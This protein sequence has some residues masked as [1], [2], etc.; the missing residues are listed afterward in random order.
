[1]SRFERCLSLCF[2]VALVAA[3]PACKRGGETTVSPTIGRRAATHEA[4]VRILE[5]RDEY[6]FAADGSYVRTTTQKYEILTQDGVEGWG[7]TGVAYSPWYMERPELTATVTSPG[8]DKAELDPSTIAESPAYPSAPDIYSDARI[9]RAPLPNVTVGAIVEEKTVVRTTKA[10]FAGGSAHSMLVQSGVAR[11][12]VELVIDLPD[13]L[14]FEF[15]IRDADIAMKERREGGRRVIAFSGGPYAALENPEPYLPKDVAT[16][17]EVQFSTGTSWQAIAKEYGEI[18]DDKL[19][20]FSVPADAMK[21]LDRRAS[22]RDKAEHM[23]AWLRKG[24]RYTG[25]EFG[26]SAIVPAV[27]KDTLGRGYGDCKDQAILLLGL[28]KEAGVDARVALLRV[29]AGEDVRPQLPALNVFDH[30]IVYVPGKD[31]LWIDPTSDYARAGE[32]P[33]PD[34]DRLALVIDGKTKQL[35]ATPRSTADDNTYREE[36]EVFLADI[37][38]SRIVETTSSTGSIERGLRGQFRST[39]KELREG[40]GEYIEGA[41]NSK[42]LGKVDAADAADLSKP[43]VFSLEAKKAK[44]GYTTLFSAEAI[45]GYGSLFEWIPTGI[46]GEQQRR[47]DLVLPLSHRTQVAYTVH[48][49]SGFVHRDPP[50]FRDLDLGAMSLTRSA[51]AKD[52]ATVIVEYQLELARP[53]LTPKDVEATKKGIEELGRE[54]EV[55]VEFVHRGSKLIEERKLPEG[56]RTFRDLADENPKTAIHRMRYARALLDLGFGDEAKRE[57]AIA[58]R[59]APDDAVL[60]TEYAIMLTRDQFGRQ[61]QDGWDRAG[62]LA[63]YEKVR[64]LEGDEPHAPVQSAVLLEHDE[65]GL[66]YTTGADLDKAIALYDSVDAD[67]LREYEQG[68]YVPNVLWALL[69]AERFDELDERLRKLPHKDVPPAV[70][71]VT[72]AA[73]GGPSDGMT[74]ADRFDLRDELRVAELTTAA[75]TLISLRKYPEAAA[76]LDSAAVGAANAVALQARAR[77]VGKL[78]AADLS[79]IHVDKPGDVVTKVLAQVVSTQKVRLGDLRSLI[80][81]R[82]WTEDDDEA[83]SKTFDTGLRDPR[84]RTVVADMV[85]SS[86]E[87]KSEG[88]DRVGYRVKA[89]ADLGANDFS[90]TA[91]GVKEKGTYRLRAWNTTRPALGSEALYWLGKGKSDHAAQWL[92]WAADLE[93]KPHGNDPLGDSTF[94][95]LWRDGKGDATVAASALA[96]LGTKPDEAIRKLRAAWLAAA[97]DDK[98]LIGRAL[99]EAYVVHDDLV[100]AVEVSASLH[101]ALPDSDVARD[102]HL[103]ALSRA[104]QWKD[105]VRVLDAG[106]AKDKD[107][108]YLRSLR[109]LAEKNRGNLA[110]A[111]ELGTALIDDERVTSGFYNEMSWLSLF[112]GKTDDK[113][114]QWALKSVQMAPSRN[115]IHTLA[116]VQLE[117]GKIADAQQSLLRLVELGGDKGLQGSDWYV[118]G[119]LAEALGLPRAAKEAYGKVEVP[120]D[121]KPNDTYLLVKKR[122]A[123][124]R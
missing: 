6:R 87:T 33:L 112:V 20:G 102:L 76:L 103:Q 88:N 17:P 119:R 51:K 22:T 4:A 85:V 66:R 116:C 32:L 90:L 19:R 114:L 50:R 97:G 73:R 74:E 98:L 59:L 86:M 36:R 121:P 57:A 5:V 108:L 61:L 46:F 48:A 60:G 71:I 13:S 96:A 80:A 120:K 111:M 100:G 64:T 92:H 123:K 52:D 24:V 68:T 53:R 14:P 26:E 9:L 1:M 49:P 84:L 83:L 72:A 99:L 30:A 113:H 70:A 8:G 104:K 44:V 25:I 21:G 42:E 27:P 77:A 18:V 115:N 78:R 16:W 107:D 58:A 117:V 40:L 122:L 28:L 109:A 37:G 89:H 65:H 93:A 39:E 23:L 35:L 38:E 91:Y 11:D 124:L 75:D 15:E 81:D 7:T 54:D 47:A 29:G 2:L 110:R 94:R 55:R 105:Y 41:Y 10:F 43:F 34:Q 101:K 67:K 45:V 3:A 62:A 82:D 106:L 118:V 56:V 79:K 31:P 95:R 69:W 63:A 12:A